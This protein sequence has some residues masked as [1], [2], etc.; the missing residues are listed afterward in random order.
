M[1]FIRNYCGVGGHTL[2]LQKLAVYTYFLRVVVYSGHMLVQYY[3]IN[4]SY[5][6]YIISGHFVVVNVHYARSKPKCPHSNVPAVA[7]HSYFKYLLG[8]TF[9]WLGGLWLPF[10]KLLCLQRSKL[11]KFSK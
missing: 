8:P 3:D 2:T 9:R 6:T 11:L 10:D 4:C 1:L 7:L 5:I